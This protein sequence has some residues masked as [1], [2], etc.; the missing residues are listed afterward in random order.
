[1]KGIANMFTFSEEL[2]E[3]FKL[4]FEFKK[5]KRKME[6]TWNGN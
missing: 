6:S 4:H 3:L 1:M 5:K 2:R